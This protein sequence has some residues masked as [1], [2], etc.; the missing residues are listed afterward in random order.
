MKHFDNVAR[1]FINECYKVKQNTSY[2]VYTLSASVAFPRSCWSHCFCSQTSSC[3]Y[4]NC[5]YQRKQT[6]TE[7]IRPRQRNTQCVIWPHNT[8]EL[9]LSRLAYSSHK[10]L[11][12]LVQQ[13]LELFT[14]C[15]CFVYNTKLKALHDFRAGA[16]SKQ[17]RLHSPTAPAVQWSEQKKQ[18]KITLWTFQ[19]GSDPTE[20][21]YA[22]CHKR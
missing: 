14:S 1:I 2:R 22:S 6:E 15:V 13:Q 21:T 18:S 11:L 5:I 8:S 19:V 9:V 17:I 10:K 20:A 4:I 16:T 3:S 12:R 7:T